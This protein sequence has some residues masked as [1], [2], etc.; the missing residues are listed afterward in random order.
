[1]KLS[2]DSILNIV[3][4]SMVMLFIFMTFQVI[5]ADPSDM[6]DIYKKTI[7]GFLSGIFIAVFLTLFLSRKRR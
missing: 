4:L 6:I 1:M 7:S 2:R 5:L 3:V